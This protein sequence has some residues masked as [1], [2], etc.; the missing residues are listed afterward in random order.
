MEGLIK[1]ALRVSLAIKEFITTA[2]WV[3]SAMKS[4]ILTAL[5]FFRRYDVNNNP[6]VILFN[7]IGYLNKYQV[8]WSGDLSFYCRVR[9]SSHLRF[10]T[11]LYN[12]PILNLET[13]S[14]HRK[15]NVVEKVQ[16]STD[17]MST[18]SPISE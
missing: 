13:N 5:A 8:P 9:Q 6:C 2:L 4:L 1:M 16:N 15:E 12:E 10:A 18:G 11:D 17:S 14:T 3:S 7:G